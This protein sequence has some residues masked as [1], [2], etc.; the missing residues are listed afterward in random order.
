MVGTNS[1]SG[2][3]GSN[4]ARVPPIAPIPS[5]V[6][7]WSKYSSVGEVNPK[8]QHHSGRSWLELRYQLQY[9]IEEYSIVTLF[10]MPIAP[11]IIWFTYTS[12]IREGSLEPFLLSLHHSFL[13]LLHLLLTPPMVLS[14]LRS[15]CFFFF[16][17]YLS[18]VVFSSSKVL[19]A[20][21]NPVSLL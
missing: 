20:S 19:E 16:F 11:T 15:S 2:G 18:N 9:S 1:A 12:H 4:A 10:I 6:V 13:L 3:A 17:A 21:A 14:C 5:T 7:G 8:I